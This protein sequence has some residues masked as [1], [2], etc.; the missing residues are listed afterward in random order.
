MVHISSTMWRIN[1]QPSN[2]TSGSDNALRLLVLGTCISYWGL[3]VTSSFSI[4]GCVLKGCFERGIIFWRA[5]I[6][7]EGHWRLQYWGRGLTHRIL[8]S[9][10]TRKQYPNRQNM[11]ESRRDKWPKKWHKID[12]FLSLWTNYCQFGH[13]CQLFVTLNNFLSIFGHLSRLDSDMFL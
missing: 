1:N 9:I 2:S 5:T 6:A 13:F 8:T 10:T 7:F 11:S 12:I 4:W 3:Q